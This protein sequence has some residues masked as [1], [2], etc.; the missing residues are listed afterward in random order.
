MFK[1]VNTRGMSHH[2]L[3]PVLAVFLVAAIGGLV[4]TR[5][6]SAATFDTNCSKTKVIPYKASKPY[7]KGE[8]VRNVQKKLIDLG[9]LPKKNAAGKTNADGI[10]GPATRAAI[11]AFQ[12]RNRL[13]TT[14]LGPKTYGKLMSKDALRKAKV[15]APAKTTAPLTGKFQQ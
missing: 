10:Y 4:M 2:L 1:K 5:N 6:S 8:C 7:T 11:R 3:L 15:T 14:G 12:V 13:E 9:Y